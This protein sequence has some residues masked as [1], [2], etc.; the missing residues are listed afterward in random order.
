MNE[1]KEVKEATFS[2]T[3]NNVT[4]VKCGLKLIICLDSYFATFSSLLCLKLRMERNAIERPKARLPAERP[5]MDDLSWEFSAS[6]IDTFPERIT[7]VNP[8]AFIVFEGRGSVSSVKNLPKL[9]KSL[10]QGFQKLWKAS[11]HTRRKT[12][13]TPA[14]V[15]LSCINLFY[16][17]PSSVSLEGIL[18]ASHGLTHKFNGFTITSERDAT[19]PKTPPQKYEDDSSVGKFHIVMNAISKFSEKCRNLVTHTSSFPKSDIPVRTTRAWCYRWEGLTE[20]RY[21]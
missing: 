9:T 10:I 13:T 2:S 6:Q 14:F 17:F 21:R 1:R 11:I 18:R 5:P 4:S 19:D 16:S 7:Q 20:N 12:Q 8:K 3:V 15:S